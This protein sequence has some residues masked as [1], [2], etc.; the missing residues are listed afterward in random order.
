MTWSPEKPKQYT[1]SHGHS[2]TDAA[3]AER[4][5]IV[6]WIWRCYRRRTE[7]GRWMTGG[8]QRHTVHAGYGLPDS[9]QFTYLIRH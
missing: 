6:P 9:R 7:C 5:V 4:A 1:R 8:S 3:D 2:E